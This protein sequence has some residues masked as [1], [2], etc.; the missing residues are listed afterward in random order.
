M[1]LPY[2]WVVIFDLMHTELLPA[3]SSGMWQ[4]TRDTRYYSQ[5]TASNLV[6]GEAH[7]RLHDDRQKHRGG[8]F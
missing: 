4:P 7:K 8:D 1:L 6:V 2:I 3:H 5:H